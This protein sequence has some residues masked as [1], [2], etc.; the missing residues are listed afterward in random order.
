[1]CCWF[2]C[3][4]S[5]P[6]TDEKSSASLAVNGTKVSFRFFNDWRCQHW[7]SSYQGNTVRKGLCKGRPFLTEEEAQHNYKTTCDVR[8]VTCM[9]ILKQTQVLISE[10]LMLAK[11]KTASMCILWE[12]LNQTIFYIY[13]F[14][15][16]LYKMECHAA[17]KM[18]FK[19][20][21]KI[22]GNTCQLMTKEGWNGIGYI[23]WL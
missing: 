2:N 7:S 15:H 5:D 20:L 14:S 8:L 4:A 1:M 12:V 6:I 17:S 22:Q 9:R 11:I 10:L 13:T 3:P 23:I 18:V 19:G 21:F 16:N